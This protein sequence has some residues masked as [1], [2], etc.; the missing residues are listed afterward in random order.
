MVGERYFPLR[1]RDPQI[2]GAVELKVLMN[3][4]FGKEKSESLAGNV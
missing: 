3:T 1:L 4:E 2:S